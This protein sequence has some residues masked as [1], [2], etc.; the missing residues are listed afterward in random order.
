MTITAKILTVVGLLFLF[1]SMTGMFVFIR[2]TAPS[3]SLLLLFFVTFVGGGI[4]SVWAQ[5]K[6]FPSKP[7]LLA[8]T[9][10][11]LSFVLLGFAR[12]ARITSSGDSFSFF[13]LAL[14]LGTVSAILLSRS[15]E[16]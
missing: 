13:I 11:Y 8:L 9:S 12:V 4:L 15:T 10:S 5:N 2:E 6:K 16:I 3:A 14:L 7:F 1:G